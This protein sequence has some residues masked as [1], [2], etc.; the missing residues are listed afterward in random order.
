[1]DGK[2]IL[3]INNIARKLT[4]IEISRTLIHTESN[5]TV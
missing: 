2:Y 1:M 5:I 3:K 4:H